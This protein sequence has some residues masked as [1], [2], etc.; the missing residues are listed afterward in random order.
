LFAALFGLIWGS[1]LN[2]I[3]WRIIRQESIVFPGSRCPTCKHSLAWYDLI[4]LFSYLI[5]RG[6]CRYC[7]ASISMLYPCIEL[8]TAVLFVLLFNQFDLPY[9]FSY[10]ILFSALIVSIRTD[11][12]HMLISRMA[13]LCLVPIGIGLSII[14]WLPITPLES[15]FGA[16]FGYSFLWITATIDV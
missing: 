4:P 6:S 5:L 1:F 9:V 3:A 14:G 7:A 13:S 15:L 8:L 11:L 2:V 16:L 10:G 12:E